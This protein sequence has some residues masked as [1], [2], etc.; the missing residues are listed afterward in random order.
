MDL[1]GLGKT[2]LGLGRMHIHIDPGR[3]QLKLQHIGRETRRREPPAIGQTDGVIDMPIA[4]GPPVDIKILPVGLAAR[5]LA[6]AE[7]APQAQI[8]LFNVNADGLRQKGLAADAK[9]A[10]FRRVGKGRQ[11]KQPLLIVPGRESHMAMAERDRPDHGLDMQIFGFF[12]FEEAAPGGRGIKQIPDF[13]RGARQMGGR[14]DRQRIIDG[15]GLFGPGGP[16]GQHKT[17]DRGD[18]RQR[19]APK[20]EARDMG[21]VGKGPELAG[22]MRLE[23]QRQIIPVNALTVVADADQ[24]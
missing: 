16:R 7:P 20:A 11:A 23:R 24:A 22:R 9:D 17:R 19:L 21:E 6:M 4:H 13:D 14:P 2:H 3:R 12:R 1:P 5:R 10:F 8:M 18:A 15:P